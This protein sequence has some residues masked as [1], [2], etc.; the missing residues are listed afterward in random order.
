MTTYGHFRWIL[1]G[2][3]QYLMQSSTFSRD[4]LLKGKHVWVGRECLRN[5]TLWS[6]PNKDSFIWQWFCVALTER[7]ES[8][9]DTLVHSL[10]CWLL[11][12]PNKILIH[13]DSRTVSFWGCLQKIMST[14]FRLCKHF[15]RGCWE[16]A[17]QNYLW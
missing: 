14:H 11:T 8:K 5:L 17:S 7:H 3:P 12:V 16:K 4:C 13:Q 6:L 9:D 1:D 15:L 2:S 10:M